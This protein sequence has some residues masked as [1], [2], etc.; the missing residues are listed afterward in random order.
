MEDLLK[1]LKEHLCVVSYEK[2]DTGQIR[3]M[4]CTLDPQRIPGNANINQR[5]DSEDI[6]VWCTDREA[7]RSFRANTMT[8]WKIID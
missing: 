4:E 6:L 7:W 8:G 3:D 5:A 1:A 2:I